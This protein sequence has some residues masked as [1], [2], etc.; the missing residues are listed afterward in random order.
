MNGCEDGQMDGWTNVGVD[1]WVGRW[2]WGQM[3]MGNDGWMD[4]CVDKWIQA[5]RMDGVE[6]R[7][8]ERGDA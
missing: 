3:N 7:A 5:R 4:G 1:G 6:W 2:M 8:D